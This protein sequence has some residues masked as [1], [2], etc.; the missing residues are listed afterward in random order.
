MRDKTAEVQDSGQVRQQIADMYRQGKSDRQMAEVLSCS[1][2]KIRYHRL[3]LDLKRSNKTVTEEDRLLIR[4]LHREGWSTRTIS[5]CIGCAAS[6]VNRVIRH[7]DTSTQSIEQ[8]LQDPVNKLLASRWT[9]DTV[10]HCWNDGGVK[11][12]DQA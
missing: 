5:E 11:R 12:G 3:Q 2:H 10:R 9:A 6:T 8:V 7:S 4:Q 1:V